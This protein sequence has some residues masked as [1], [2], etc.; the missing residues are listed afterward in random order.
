MTDQRQIQQAQQQ[1]DRAFEA[2]ATARANVL[3]VAAAAFREWAPRTA[4][5]RVTKNH[6]RATAAGKVRVQQLRRDVEDLVAQADEL[7]ET[8]LG[9]A[10]I[11]PHLG[12]PEHTGETPKL[13]PYQSRELV[14]R[15]VGL[16]A[17]TIGQ[18]L[19]D[20]GLEQTTGAG[21]HWRTDNM[22][23]ERP[24]RVLPA[25][26]VE[27]LGPIGAA[28]DDYLDD[29]GDLQAAVIARNKA[30]RLAGEAEAA[31]LWD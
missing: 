27:M 23:S 1:V 24:R 19:L 7:V 22:F 3:T 16:L 4:K 17:G 14:E 28:Y 15:P 21:I 2:A 30:I 11:W 31:D 20:A 6:E 29:V 10:D 26:R 8:E 9:K 25:Y 5:D 12:L 13:Q 18:L